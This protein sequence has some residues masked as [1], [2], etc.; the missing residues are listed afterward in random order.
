MSDGRILTQKNVNLR[1]EPVVTDSLFLMET[2]H[3]KLAV[4]H[5]S[6]TLALYYAFSICLPWWDRWNQ[7]RE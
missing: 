6:L 3:I 2:L 1:V 7:P 5:V 4:L